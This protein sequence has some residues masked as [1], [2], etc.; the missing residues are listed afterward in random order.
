MRTIDRGTRY[1]IVGDGQLARHLTHYFRE[2]GLEVAT[3]S[4]RAE[5]DTGSALGEAL[6]GAGVVLLLINDDAIV[7]FAAGHPEL[8]DRT[9]VHCAGALVTPDLIGLHPLMTFGP[10]LLSLGGYRAV[11]FVGDLGRPGFRD[12]FPALP[13]PSYAIPVEKKP[14]YHAL[15]SLAGNLTPVLWERFIAVLSGELGLPH[16]VV[17]PYFEAVVTRC[18][19]P[20]PFATTGPIVRG[21]RETIA[22]HLQALRHEALRPVYESFVRALGPELLD[23]E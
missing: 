23:P 10:T 1:G 6:A 5:R 19:G 21:D 18:R 3:W 14:L 9:L 13:N 16:E 20:L 8:A 22:L 11:P 7:P 15:A 2:S 17:S 12:L 4:R